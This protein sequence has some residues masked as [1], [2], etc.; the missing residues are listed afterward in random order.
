MPPLPGMPPTVFHL[1]HNL[2]VILMVQLIKCSSPASIEESDRLAEKFN[3]LAP[4]SYIPTQ[5]VTGEES[6]H[7]VT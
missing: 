4:S 3:E 7:E 2:V 6:A 5:S 1:A